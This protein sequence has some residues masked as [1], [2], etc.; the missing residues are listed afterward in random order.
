MT[1]CTHPS[2]FVV[3]LTGSI[4]HHACD[5]CR[6]AWWTDDGEQVFTAAALLK[7]KQHI[8]ELESV[9]SP[10]LA[11]PKTSLLSSTEVAKVFAVTP[12]TVINWA[13]HGKL[14]SY[15]TAGRQLRFKY[16][17]VVALAA[18]GAS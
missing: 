2:E 8:Q 7:L 11:V 15:R 5:H 13:I 4:S 14:R 3:P 1:A 17:D 16:D 10:A 6:T 18:K 12:R 9:P